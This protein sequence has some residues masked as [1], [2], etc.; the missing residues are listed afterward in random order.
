MTLIHRHGTIVATAS[1]R[2]VHF[3]VQL[4]DRERRFVTAM[5]AYARDV[6]TGEL[7]GPYS[8]QNAERYARAFLV[9][10]TLFERN[11]DRPDDE[12]AR[13]FDVPVDQI[14]LMRSESNGTSDTA[15]DSAS[16]S[17]SRRTT[18]GGR[19]RV[20]V[21]RGEADVVVWE[22]DHEEL[23]FQEHEHR[24][25]LAPAALGVRLEYSPP[26]PPRE[27]TSVVR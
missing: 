9:D 11:R 7:A 24:K 19:W 22:G 4:S 14:A 18:D 15:S 2:R 25:R 6:A 16:G 20:V 26:L 27:W 17:D 10:D 8:T 13:L 3:T 23:A 12:L 21:T 5:A 1:R